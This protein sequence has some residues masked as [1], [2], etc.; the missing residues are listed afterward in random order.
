MNVML[1]LLLVGPNHTLQIK[2][3][4]VMQL[5]Q[6]VKKFGVKLNKNIL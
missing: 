6:S 4:N 5:A 3:R 2:V 1:R